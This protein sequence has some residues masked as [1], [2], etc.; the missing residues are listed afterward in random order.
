MASSGMA[1]TSSSATSDLPH[2]SSIYSLTIGELMGDP[3]KNLGSMSMDDLIRNVYAEE[4]PP[5]YGSG[6]GGAAAELSRQGS[7]LLPKGMGSMT[8]EEVWRE[9]SGGKRASGVD[10]G[11]DG[12]GERSGYTEAVPAANGEVTLEDFLTR[13]GAVREED[14]R[15]PPGS[16]PGGFGVDPVSGQQ[17]MSFE[18]PILSFGNGMESGGGG[19]AGRGRKRTVLDPEDTVALQRQKRMI[20]NRESAARSRER[21]QAY[22]V[23]L[24]SLVTQLEEEN[25]A[26]QR[27]QDELL[28]LRFKQD[29]MSLSCNG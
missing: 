7:F 3:V 10:D 4:G 5:A 26:L 8:V 16:M 2:Q 18:N 14:V 21:K 15:V 19:R 9:I 25:N 27:E 6:E 29:I 12:G 23:E 11:G 1:A 24:E 20:K 17:Q 22:T 13:A 28:K